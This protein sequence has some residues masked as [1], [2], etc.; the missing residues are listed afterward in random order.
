MTKRL[1]AALFAMSLVF[2]ACGSDDDDEADTTTTA[3][4]GASDTTMADSTTMA[5]DMGASSTSHDMGSMDPGDSMGSS[6][7]MMGSETTMAGEEVGEGGGNT[8][9]MP[10]GLDADQQA[11]ADVW[12]E[13][14][15]SG[16]T[17]GAEVKDMVQDGDE[18]E[19]VLDAFVSNPLAT[20]V[21][22]EVKDVTVE[23][24]TATLDM[25]FTV[26]GGLDPLPIPG[27]SVKVDGKWLVGRSTICALG[28]AI[29]VPCPA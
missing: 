20:E 4:E 15:T 5:D 9:E 21:S 18:L 17:S 19:G 29:Q 12:K 24:D 2:A 3:G 25:V 6:T 11:A 10:D 14:L 13:F 7:T 1:L 16:A 8:F 27:E 28:G 26:P 23:G 22:V